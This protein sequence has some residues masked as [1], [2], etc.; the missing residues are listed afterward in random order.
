MTSTCCCCLS[1]RVPPLPIS[2][3]LAACHTPPPHQCPG[4]HTPPPP[5][6]CFMSSVPRCFFY[7]DKCAMGRKRLRSSALVTSLGY[8]L[9]Q[10]W[11]CI[12]RHTCYFKLRVPLTY[13]VIQENLELYRERFA[14]K[15]IS[16]FFFKP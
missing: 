2:V 12:F 7:L 8:C 16:L 10:Y 4:G 9:Y 15:I 11:F 1:G 5:A 13:P 6:H 3:W 14:N